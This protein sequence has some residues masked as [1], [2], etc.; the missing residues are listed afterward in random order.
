MARAG[1]GRRRHA[2]AARGEDPPGR[3]DGRAR[4][5]RGG[6]HPLRAA[7]RPSRATRATRRRPACR[8]T[9]WSSTASPASTKLEDGDILSVDVGVTLDGFV[10]DSAWT[11]PVGR[12][13]PRPSGCSRSAAPR[14]RPGS[15]RR[16]SATRSATSPRPSSGHRGGRLQRDPQPGRPRGR[17]LDARGPAGAQLRLPRPR[18]GAQGGHDD[19]DR[20]DDHRRGPEVYIHD[21]EWSISTADG[22]LAAH[23]EHTVAVTARASHPDGKTGV[24]VR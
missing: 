15:S 7:S 8:R 12:S 10:A 5:D 16:G 22:S 21:D 19:R 11:F 23:F 3:D 4:R 18:P 9:R 6:V 2:G 1:R 20:A 14:S 24:L 13:R 17:P